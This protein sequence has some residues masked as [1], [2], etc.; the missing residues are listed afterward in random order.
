MQEKTLE[1]YLE[2]LYGW[3]GPG[4][5]DLDDLEER[6]LFM[7]DVMGAAYAWYAARTPRCEKCGFWLAQGFD[8]LWRCY[9]KHEKEE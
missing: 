9:R 1:E 8:G 5:P 3:V 4:Y 2:R 6:E 7:K